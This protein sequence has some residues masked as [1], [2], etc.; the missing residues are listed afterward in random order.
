M[1][2][3]RPLVLAP[4]EPIKAPR[5][6]YNTPRT[7]DATPKKNLEKHFKKTHETFHSSCVPPRASAFLAEASAPSVSTGRVWFR[8]SGFGCR[9]LSLPLSL[10]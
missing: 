10:V 7:P 8:V 1:L 6:P 2:G 5:D 3:L 4:Y 9:V